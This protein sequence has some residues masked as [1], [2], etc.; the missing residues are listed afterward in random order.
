MARHLT[1]LD[2]EDVP[3]ALVDGL[4]SVGELQHSERYLDGNCLVGLQLDDTGCHFVPV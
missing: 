4:L 1:D 3:V 2:M